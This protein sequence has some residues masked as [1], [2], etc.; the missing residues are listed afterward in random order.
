MEVKKLDDVLDKKFKNDNIL[1]KFINIDVEGNDTNVIKGFEK[2]LPKTEY[3][4]FECSDCLDDHRGPGIKNPMKDIVDFL[5]KNDFN[6]YRIGTK[7]LF[8]VNDECWDDVYE[9]IK[10]Y[11]NC[12]S[13]KK[14]NL[15][16]NSLIDNEYN[17]II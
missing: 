11:S 10:F 14:N 2:C 17:Y 7:K 5:S 15:I 4:I 1:I 9:K 12:F 3:I 8:K 6:T 13:L 16:I